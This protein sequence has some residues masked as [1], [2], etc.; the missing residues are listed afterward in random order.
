MYVKIGHKSKDRVI[1][2]KKTPKLESSCGY[3]YA[4]D[5]WIWVELWLMV[6]YRMYYIV[7]DEGCPLS[8]RIINWSNIQFVLIQC[9]L[10]H[11]HLLPELIIILIFLPL[12]PCFI[13]T[14]LRQ[15]CWNVY[16]A[17]LWSVIIFQSITV[18]SSYSYNNKKVY[19]P[20]NLVFLWE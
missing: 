3:I 7:W 14:V 10:H 1:C 6:L 13:Y 16:S 20:S 17:V 4:E 9:A 2:P 12:L 15:C 18:H 19:R 8:N 5:F 11:M